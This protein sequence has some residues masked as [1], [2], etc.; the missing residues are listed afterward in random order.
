MDNGTYISTEYGP[1]EK[2]K[3]PFIREM[4]IFKF[5]DST[6]P[7]KMIQENVGLNQ[8]RLDK[9]ENEEEISKWQMEKK[10]SKYR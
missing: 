3:F 2:I 10:D 9:A 8:C 7:S 5:F 6:S 4:T 1:G